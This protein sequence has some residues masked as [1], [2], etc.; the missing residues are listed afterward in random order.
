[1]LTVLA[2]VAISVPAEADHGLAAW[3]VVIGAVI[4][5]STTLALAR[6][7]TKAGRLW[8]T[9]LDDADDLIGGRAA[10]SND[11]FIDLDFTE[12][13]ADRKELQS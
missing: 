3:F 7:A 5:G 1:M 10:P 4:V 9:T 12:V 2:L 6:L 11:S 13:P 8:R